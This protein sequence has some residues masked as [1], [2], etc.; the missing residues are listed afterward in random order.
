MYIIGICNIIKGVILVTGINYLV[1]CRELNSD[2]RGYEP[3][4]RPLTAQK[5]VVVF[6]WLELR[7]NRF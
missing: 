3:A 2:L 5:S 4:K 7:L 1:G 6:L